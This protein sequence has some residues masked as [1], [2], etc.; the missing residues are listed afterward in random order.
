MK[1][2]PN[3]LMMVVLLGIIGVVGLSAALTVQSWQRQGNEVYWL[4]PREW[5]FGKTQAQ[6]ATD[7]KCG[8]FQLNAPIGKRML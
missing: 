5:G 7:Y 6:S 4:S 1:R 2:K 3:A 8:F